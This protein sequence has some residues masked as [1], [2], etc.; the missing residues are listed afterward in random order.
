LPKLN[1]DEWKNWIAYAEKDREE[2]RN[3]FLRKSWSEACF[4]A[5]QSCEKLLKALLMKEGTFLPIHDLKNLL[6]EL[7]REKTELKKLGEDLGELTV[8]Y[9]AARYPDAAMRFNIV[10]TRENAR[11]CVEVMEKLWEISKGYLK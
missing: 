2:A 5:Q 3:A 4:H 10:Y 1:S 7:V 11:R 9:Y 8:H 6:I